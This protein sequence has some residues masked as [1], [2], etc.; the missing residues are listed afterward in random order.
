MRALSS[1]TRGLCKSPRP[2]TPLR[3]AA[4]PV[5]GALLDPAGPLTFPAR[6]LCP[7]PPEAPTLQQEVSSAAAAPT[8]SPSPEA[9]DRGRRGEP[10]AGVLSLPERL[11]HSPGGSEGLRRQ[12]WSVVAPDKSY[13]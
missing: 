4:S 10:A 7:H 5:S 9:E 8:A 13:F 12:P 1:C 3:A 11:G 6:V 2:E